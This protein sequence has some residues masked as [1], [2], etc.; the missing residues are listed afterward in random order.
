MRARIHH[1]GAAAMVLSVLLVTASLTIAE[2]R[3]WLYT[4]PYKK[5]QYVYDVFYDELDSAATH[6]HF[7]S[8]SKRFSQ[9]EFDE[10]ISELSSAETLALLEATTRPLV[11]Y[12]VP[13]ASVERAA[14]LLRQ[15]L[16]DSRGQR[17]AELLPS[18]WCY[19]SQQLAPRR[20]AP[21]P[22]VETLAF[23]RQQH[24]DKVRIREACLGKRLSDKLFAEQDR[25]TEQ[26]LQRRHRL[27]G[28]KLP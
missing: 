19:E 2:R 21:Q 14:F 13:A 10:S 24:A 26:L 22:L 5:P 15:S 25:L 16:P 23:Q 3:Q 8:V 9:L 4:S 11:A 18:Y 6:T 17:L 7:H 27:N 28:E 12:K 1:I 20:N